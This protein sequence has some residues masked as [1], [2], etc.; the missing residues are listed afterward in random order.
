[1]PTNGAMSTSRCYL[2][3]W[4]YGG[5]ILVPRYLFLALLSWFLQ[6]SELSNLHQCQQWCRATSLC[7]SAPRHRRRLIL[8]SR[9]IFLAM[10]NWFEQVSELSYVQQQFLQFLLGHFKAQGHF[11]CPNICFWQC[12]GFKTVT[13]TQTPTTPKLTQCM[14]QVSLPNVRSEFTEWHNRVYHWRMQMFGSIK[15]YFLEL[16]P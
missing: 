6:D 2:A 14:E 11:G 3:L 13:C 8:V 12:W 1:M 7:N 15:W 16:R 4:H 9:Y 5:M 10:L